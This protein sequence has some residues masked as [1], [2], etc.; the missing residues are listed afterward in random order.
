MRMSLHYYGQQLIGHGHGGLG[1][2]AELLSCSTRFPPH[3]SPSVPPC[4]FLY[5]SLSLTA[6]L[7]PSAAP[8]VYVGLGPP[9]VNVDVVYRM[10]AVGRAAGR[11]RRDVVIVCVDLPWWLSEHARVVKCECS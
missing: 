1:V 11:R 6:S 9:D 8:V 10:R 5:L 2:T 3:S 7:P 4:S